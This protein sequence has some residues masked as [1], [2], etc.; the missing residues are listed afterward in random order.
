MSAKASAPWTFGGQ[1]V[2]GGV[3]GLGP[4][5][6]AFGV[7]HESPVDPVHGVVGVQPCG[8]Q[9]ECRLGELDLYAHG[10][11]P[12]AVDGGRHGLVR[13]RFPH[14]G[15]G[16]VPQPEQRSDQARRQH[17]REPEGEGGRETVRPARRG[18]AASRGRG[19]GEHAMVGHHDV[20]GDQGV[21]GGPPHAHGVPGVLAHELRG[22]YENQRP[23]GGGAGPVPE[24]CADDGPCRIRG[25]GVVRPPPGDRPTT[26]NPS[27]DPRRG[28]GSRH[29][30]MRG[31]PEHLVLSPFGE[32]AGQ[33]VRHRDAHRGPGRRPVRLTED[34]R[35][36]HERP[37]AGLLSA[38]TPRGQQPE[39]PRIGQG[40]DDRRGDRPVRLPAFRLRPQPRLEGTGALHEFFP[41][42]RGRRRGVRV[43]LGAAGCHD[44][45]LGVLVRGA[46]RTR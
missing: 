42:G 11:G 14:R 5:A 2:L 41:G 27:A 20:P 13:R 29:P 34:L 19:H 9:L 4:D 33:P 30:G 31:G 7:V 28:G 37:Q 46:S 23:A 3:A 44:V 32:A 17:R 12:P 39:D 6:G 25:G 15:E 18:T 10:A 26:G 24:Q 38:E 43:G 8:T 40:V 36:L 16:G 1:D 22:G 45:L 35:D 21:T